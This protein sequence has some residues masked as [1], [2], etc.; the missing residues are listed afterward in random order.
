MP[1]TPTHSSVFILLKTRAP[2][3]SAVDNRAGLSG[4]IQERDAFF[5]TRVAGQCSDVPGAGA[6]LYVVSG[7]TRSTSSDV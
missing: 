6:T 2:F 3:A 5:V 4:M 7:D 1:P